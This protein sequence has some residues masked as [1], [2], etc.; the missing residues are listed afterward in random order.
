MFVSSTCYDLGQVRADLKDFLESVGIQPVLSEY[1]TFPVNPDENTIENCLRVV[2]ENADLFLLVVGSK[3]GPIQDGG[4]SITN[5]EYLRA[6]AKGIPIYVFV[7][8]AI[9]NILPVWRDNPDGK[10]DSI[11]DSSKIFEFVESMRSIEGIWVFPF[12]KA[13]EIANTLR[14][15]LAYLFLDALQ[16]R[17]R[18]KMNGL[19]DSLA[20]LHGTPL[21]LVIDKSPIWEHRLFSHTVAQEFEKVNAQ[22]LD[23][24]YGI[25]L[26]E[27]EYLRGAN[28]VIHWIRKKNAEAS[29]I[30]DA[31]NQ[32]I[33]VALPQAL[34]EPGMPG[35]PEKIV[36]VARRFASA[37]EHAIE[38]SLEA[39]RVGVDDENCSGLISAVGSFLAETITEIERFSRELYDENENALLTFQANPNAEITI[40]LTLK[41]T[42]SNLD[43]FNA[44][45]KKFR[46]YYG[47]EGE[48]DD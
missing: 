48:W 45:L 16:L 12:E 7:E 17:G 40:N 37:Y 21:K 32:I 2:D 4:K 8:K 5:M 34:G 42:L 25:A 41:L 11:T 47:L 39:K 19:P 13:G 20:S 6:R 44:E 3:Y 29:R 18:L 9:I 28:D 24:Q 46:K 35:D 10:Y 38:W 27:A 23:L 15:Q 26:G 30:V 43:E 22:K 36:Y 31:T 1:P 33:N 14:I